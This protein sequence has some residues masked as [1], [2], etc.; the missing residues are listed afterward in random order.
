[1][2]IYLHI[3]YHKTGSS[4]LQML[5]SSNRDLLRDLGVH[6]P[7]EERDEDAKL[8]RISPGNG[9]RL[10]KAIGTR[11]KKD[12]LDI[13]L[14]WIKEATAHKCRALLISNEGLFHSMSRNDYH[15]LFQELQKVTKIS[16]IHG[17]LFLRDPLD[18][19][20][21]L[22]K[23]RGKRGA[24]PDF[25]TWVEEDYETLQ[26]TEKFL[27]KTEAN[28]QIHFTLRKYKN[29]S[30]FLADAV[31]KEWLDIPTPPIPQSDRVNASLSLSE[32]M[33]LDNV[34]AQLGRERAVKIQKRLLKNSKPKP[35]DENLKHLYGFQIYSFLERQLPLIKRVNDKMSE[36]EHL[37]VKSQD[38]PQEKFK[39]VTLTAEQLKIIIEEASRKAG[40]KYKMLQI[41]K[42]L[43]G[44][45]RK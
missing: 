18:H 31:F 11:N 27:D 23:H 25:K 6:Y 38:L 22:Y 8:G 37:V 26:L 1:M 41:V 15:D 32:I 10:A 16:E 34:Y 19:I 33:V 35:K 17:L 2:R 21:S 24:I 5:L 40:L 28:P 20:F 12:F 30:K 44:K 36:E 13:M 45:I 4:F 7:S 3:G 29:D 42:E 9:L 43:Y 39:V 14:L